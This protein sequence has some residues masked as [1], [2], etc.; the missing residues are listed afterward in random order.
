MAGIEHGVCGV[1]THAA[2]VGPG[3]PLAD[4]L[5]VLRRDEGRTVLAVAKAK[6][7]HLLAFEEL[8]DNDLRFAFAEKRAAEES[9][10]GFGC[11]ST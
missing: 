3:V 5:V 9:F 10:G 4:A 8:F 11:N 6:E 1:D 2:G 7:T